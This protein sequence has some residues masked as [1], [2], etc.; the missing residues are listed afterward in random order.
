MAEKK[1]LINSK[2]KNY[3]YGKFSVW[4]VEKIQPYICMD[5]GFC[6]IV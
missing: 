4:L 3:M 5:W 1:F 2:R 6:E